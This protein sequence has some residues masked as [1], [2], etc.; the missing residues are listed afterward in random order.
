MIIVIGLGWKVG[1]QYKYELR[2][3]A[4]VGLH[5]VANQYSGVLIKG[6]VTIVPTAERQLWLRVNRAQYAELHANLTHGWAT[7]VPDNKLHYH[8]LP[9]TSKPIELR[10]KNGT[11]SEQFHLKFYPKY[12]QIPI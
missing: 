12:P 11:V 7:F 6:Q 3:R 5:Q 4:L 9:L 1:Q 2:S 8:E 10:L